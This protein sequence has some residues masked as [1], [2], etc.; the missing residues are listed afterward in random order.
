M[1]KKMKF[2]DEKALDFLRDLRALL[3]KHN[4]VYSLVVHADTEGDLYFGLDVVSD[5]GDRED[6][7]GRLETPLHVTVEK[8][9]CGNIYAHTIDW[10]I[11]QM[12]AGNSFLTNPMESERGHENQAEA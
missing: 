11:S 8:Y 1:K 12:E 2:A 5:Y 7:F 9:K 4:D 10:I 6:W 3:K